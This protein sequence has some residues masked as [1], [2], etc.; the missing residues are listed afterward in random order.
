MAWNRWNFLTAL[1]RRYD[2]AGVA[3][4]APYLP[5]AEAEKLNSGKNNEWEIR[6]F[7]GSSSQRLESIH[8]SWLLPAVKQLDDAF[9]PYVVAAL[10]ETLRTSLAKELGFTPPAAPSPPFC[11]ILLRRLEES[12]GLPN[13][14]PLEAMMGDNLAGLLGMTKEA[15]MKLADCFAMQDIAEDIRCIVD[16]RKLKQL[17][18]HLTPYQ[19]RYLKIC[20]HQKDRSGMP[21][22]NIEHWDGAPKT[23]FTMIHRRGLMRLGKTLSGS[24]PE[25]LWHLCQRLDTG[26]AKILSRHYHIQS[27]VNVTDSL[28]RQLLKLMTIL[29]KAD[30]E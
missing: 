24:D 28:R 27:V 20:L 17:Y 14:P 23:L 10:P 18:R 29:K 11:E 30:R 8:Y 4:I 13:H 7:V 22:V 19:H 5:S 1:A 9:R 2:A 25:F 3:A 6:E 21:K 26:R 16:K 12:Y 15:L